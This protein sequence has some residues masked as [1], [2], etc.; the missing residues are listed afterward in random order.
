MA[1]RSYKTFQRLARNEHKRNV[2]EERK[3]L[4]ASKRTWIFN[5]GIE[6]TTYTNVIYGVTYYIIQVKGEYGEHC[7]RNRGEANN[8]FLKLKKG[9]I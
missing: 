1:Y 2:E 4:E 7:F 8:Y 6:V 9:E 5:N 3:A